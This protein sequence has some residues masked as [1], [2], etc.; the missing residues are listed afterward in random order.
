MHAVGGGV[1]RLARVHHQH[2][3]PRA[4][5]HQGAVQAGR[6]AADDYHLV[7]IFDLFRHAITSAVDGAPVGREVASNVAN[8]AKDRFI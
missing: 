3:A 4:G 2:R 5:Q 7:R 6:P 1:A 8:P